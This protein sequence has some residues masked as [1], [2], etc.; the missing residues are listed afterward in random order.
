M[1]DAMELTLSL[2]LGV[3]FLT[4]AIPK[5]RRPKSF[6]LVVLEYRILPPFIGEI[7]ARLVPPLELFVALLLLTGTA[8]QVG[9]ALASLLLISFAIAVGINLVRGRD[10][11]CGC[12]GEGRG[13]RVGWYL[14]MRD[15]SLF[16]ASIVLAAL[17]NTW[18]VQEPWAVL[19]S[20]GV[21]EPAAPVMC[22]AAT[23]CAAILLGRFPR[24]AR[25]WRDSLAGR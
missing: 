14:L 11:D 15:T 25:T 17:S 4:S 9:A 12:F 5:L 2:V 8:T 16:I 21:A 20:V 24:R 19:R 6:I 10:L 22:A 23:A 3:V 13:T 7:F 1:R 18:G